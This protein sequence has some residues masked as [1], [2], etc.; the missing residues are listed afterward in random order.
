MIVNLSGFIF[1][2][3]YLEYKNKKRNFIFKKIQE[4]YFKDFRAI[5]TS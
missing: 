3:I 2:K 5:K 4:A 1:F